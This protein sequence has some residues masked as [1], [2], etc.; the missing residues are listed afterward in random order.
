[1][2][3]KF[4]FA[5]LL[6]RFSDD[7]RG[8]AS[9]NRKSVVDMFTAPDAE[10]VIKFWH[11]MSFGQVDL[12]GSTAWPAAGAANLGWITLAQKQS[13]YQGS[14][15]NSQGRQDLVDWAKSAARGAN[16]PVDS[17]DGVVVYMSTATD[18]WG[19]GGEVVCDADANLTQILQEVGHALG[20][21][22]H[23]RAV[24][25]GPG[26]DYMDPF[27]IMSGMT[28]GNV[29]TGDVTFQGAFGTS[30]PGL[31]AP[32]I[33]KM[34]WLDS[35][36]IA[37][38]AAPD[39]RT[40]RPTAVRLS[41]LG[42]QNPANP[43]AAVFDLPPGRYFVEY[44]AGGWDRGLRQNAIVVHQYRADQYAYYAGNI[45]TSTVVTP[46]GTTLLPGSTYL[47]LQADLSVRLLSILDEGATAMIQIAAAAA[48][49]TISVRDVA[50][51]VLHLQ[52][53]FSMRQQVC[54]S[55][56]V[57]NCLLELLAR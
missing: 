16:V 34:G 11:D 6:C 52:G 43:Q 30:G 41:A 54:N 10:N 13:D 20:L 28:F 31:C 36:R 38:V 37:S 50:R 39:G 25:S 7:Q 42:D 12:S 55:G 15:A 21:A 3:R 14:G 53:P 5:V 9:I 32:Y 8:F 24:S 1:M 33:A 35:H 19:G 17:F 57:R 29:P 51:S 45:P 47:D 48:I 46:G 56:S 18:L 49:Q 26:V 27:C 40:P 23:S 4:S 22:T 44:R 2:S